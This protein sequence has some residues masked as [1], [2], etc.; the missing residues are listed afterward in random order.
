ME[1]EV[2]PLSLLLSFWQEL[3][4][5]G[6]VQ[7]VPLSMMNIV[8]FGW[9]VLRLFHQCAQDAVVPLL[10]GVVVLLLLLLGVVVELLMS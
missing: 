6:L 1:V 9:L 4:I 2:A 10:L 5:L 3:G 8:Q 7:A